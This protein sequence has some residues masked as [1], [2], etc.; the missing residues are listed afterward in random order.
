[1]QLFGAVGLV[2]A[3]RPLD[4]THEGAYLLA[5]G[6]ARQKLQEDLQVGRA[7]Q[8]FFDAHQRH[9]NPGSAGAKADVAFVFDQDY[10]AGLGHHEVG[11]ADAHV[12]GQKRLAQHL[13][14][15]GG[16]LFGAGVGA[17]A[18]L[19][20]EEGADFLETLVDR[21]PHDV[22]GGLARQLDD[23]LAQVGLEDLDPLALE[24]VVDLHLLAEHALPLDHPAHAVALHQIVQDLPYVGGVFGPM[25][26]RA[27]GAKAGFRF[28]QVLVEPAQQVPFDGGRPVAPSLGVYLAVGALAVG[29][30]VEGGLGDRVAHV[31]LLGQ[32]AFGGG[33]V[34][35]SH[36]GPPKAGWPSDAP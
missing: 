30:E 22:A 14:G 35:L 10:G 6:G 20:V 15:G 27:G 7:R 29:V 5:G 25:D 4:E 34:A 16:Q 19:F 8:Q 2:S 1:M 12:G 23:V 31:R 13:A 36:C 32:G 26:L 33:L 17:G 9:V 24:V 3:A 28:G 11:A 18:E 21:R